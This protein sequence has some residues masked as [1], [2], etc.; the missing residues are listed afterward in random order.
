MHETAA[1][2]RAARAAAAVAR[3]VAHSAGHGA[4]RKAAAHAMRAIGALGRIRPVAG[5]LPISLRIG[6]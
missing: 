2:K 6:R 4:S 3:E 5:Y 1:A